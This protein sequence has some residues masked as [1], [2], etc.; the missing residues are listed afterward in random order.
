MSEDDAK[1]TDDS[2]A[3]FDA[4][5]E[6][7]L[8]DELTGE[9]LDETD[10]AVDDAPGMSEEG[11]YPDDDDAGDAD[12]NDDDAGEDD[13]GGSKDQ[14]GWDKERQRVQQVNANLQKKL[15]AQDAELAALR[16]KTEDSKDDDAGDE[17]DDDDGGEPFEEDTEI[18]NLYGELDALNM[19]PLDELSD[20]DDMRKRL[21]AQSAILGKITKLQQLRRKRE[22]VRDKRIGYG[23]SMRA[24]QRCVDSKLQSVGLGK[25]QHNELMKRCRAVCTKR[26]YDENRYPDA[27]TTGDIVEAQA[28]RLA[29]ELEASGATKK[30]A[31]RKEPAADVGKGGPR[32]TTTKTGSP[33]KA[34]K[35]GT[36]IRETVEA[37]LGRAAKG[38]G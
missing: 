37:S 18:G 1:T 28:Y 14:K 6:G 34:A 33:M 22:Q 25:E 29:K 35:F 38:G 26:G 31:P 8:R 24:L 11:F 36:T 9:L 21:N 12:G 20:E 16:D 5:V 7:E 10:S 23:R 13:E 2:D 3:G 19:E 27:D 32:K 30:A 4:I 17:G 15:D